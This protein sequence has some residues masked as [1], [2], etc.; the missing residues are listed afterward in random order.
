MLNLTG[1]HNA[2]FVTIAHCPSRRDILQVSIHSWS[3]SG[4][5]LLYSRHLYKQLSNQHFARQFFTAVIWVLASGIRRLSGVGRLTST[6][7]MLSVPECILHESQSSFA[8]ACDVVSPVIQ[9]ITAIPRE[10]SVVYQWVY[11]FQV[12]REGNTNKGS[13][14]TPKCVL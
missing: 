3:P 9:R 11:S 13:L 14:L 5:F 6:T 1:K 10:A 12:R 2:A 8:R 4:G 7:Q